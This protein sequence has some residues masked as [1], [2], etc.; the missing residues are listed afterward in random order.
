[1]FETFFVY[2]FVS[3]TTLV[4]G[5]G[6]KKLIILSENPRH[7]IAYC[8]K[9]LL[10][11]TASISLTWVMANYTLAA[12]NMAE[13][14]PFFAVLFTIFFSMIFQRFIFSSFKIDTAEFT[15]T[16][17]TVILAVAEGIDF[18]NAMI[19]GISSCIAFYLLIPFLSAIR[20]RFQ[21]LAIPTDLTT[22]AL[23]FISLAL[24]ILALYSWNVSW[25][26]LGV[27]K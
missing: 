27:Y 21:L 11:I 22:G 1:M 2:I 26:N 8:L 19:I 13:I 16:F 12:F 9:S 25:L 15:L 20:K 6:F 4:Y 24:I 14:Y 3:S 7:M 5:L 23:V 10:S 18:S 17:L